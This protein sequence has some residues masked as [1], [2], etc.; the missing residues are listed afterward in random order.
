MTLFW[1]AVGA[2]L[3]FAVAAPLLALVRS[4][5]EASLQD[6][7]PEN[8]RIARERLA[9]LEQERR[10]G[11]MDAEAFERAK[12]DLE[13][14]LAAD[15]AGAESGTRSRRGGNW[16]AVAVLLVVPA[17]AIPMYFYL[18]DP[19]AVDGSQVATMPAD[20]PD[21]AEQQALPSVDEMIARLEARLQQ[22]PDDAQGWYMLG[23]T[24]L[25]LGRY[26]PAARALKRTQE[27]V[28]DE[29][30]VLVAYAD[31]LAMLQGGS[32]EGEPMALVQR[33]LAREP[34]S[35]I[36]LWLAGM[37][38]QQAGELDQAISLWEQAKQQM[39]P[40][41][42]ARNEIQSLIDSAKAAGGQA[43]AA[44]TQA[45][46]APSAA[47]SGAQ[48]KITVDLA[49]EVKAKAGS[50]DTVFVFATPPDGTRMPVAAVK[51]R[52]ADLPLELQ[53]S[54]EDAVA[55]VARLSNYRQV[56]VSARISKSGNAMPA[57]GDWVA[58]PQTVAVDSDQVTHLVID[59][60]VP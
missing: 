31:A 25:A 56:K 39:P 18:G 52:V 55:P 59:Q 2:M 48:V 32:L 13:T 49:P 33:A 57:S 14:A 6:S 29:P 44:S 20:H 38:H 22:E 9:E 58:A 5:T 50:D 11:A 4:R 23:R 36:A 15:L 28:G 35:P 10:A 3:V 24:Y 43:S 60:S 1:F 17:L 54:D 34:E 40:D 45:A 46:P 30:D 53:L 21:V 27:L 37:G 12:D 8:I 51:R 41:A 19:A 16:A 26:E 42:E 7:Q 47:M